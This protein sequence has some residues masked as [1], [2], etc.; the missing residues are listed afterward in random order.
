MEPVEPEPEE[1]QSDEEFL[2]DLR[3]DLDRFRDT[4]R[5]QL[6]LP[7]SPDL[8]AA[9]VVLEPVIGRGTCKRL[10]RCGIIQGVKLR[11]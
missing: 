3:A 6:N 1:Q 5:E 10:R 9:G 7:Q 2:R 4:P 11:Y 8:A